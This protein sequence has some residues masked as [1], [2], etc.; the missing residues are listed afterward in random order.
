M[1]IIANNA[2]RMSCV[3]LERVYQTRT[4]LVRSLVKVGARD[5]KSMSIHNLVIK[6]EIFSICFFN[7][8]RYSSNQN[9]SGGYSSGSNQ[10]SWSRCTYNFSASFGAVVAAI[11]AAWG[12]Y[13][14]TVFVKNKDE[15]NAAAK[16]KTELGLISI[17]PLSSRTSD[18]K[19]EL[20]SQAQNKL[21]VIG[22]SGLS[23]VDPKKDSSENPIY[24]AIR[25]L[26]KR[27]VEVNLIIYDEK[28]A[29]DLGLNGS[30]VENIKK[31]KKLAQKLQEE[32]CKYKFN[33][34]TVSKKLPFHGDLIDKEK[35]CIVRV[36]IG[37][38]NSASAMIE[39]YIPGRSQYN[40]FKTYS[41]DFEEIW[42]KADKI[43]KVP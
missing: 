29:D 32:D 5:D 17:M 26:L 6:N 43:K 25:V 2:G 35:A 15:E 9:G 36:P 27:G 24:E 37:G 12:A 16:F 11:V 3:A 10:E 42:E 1:S 30:D 19:A 13:Q 20:Y 22:V 8:R 39:T 21:T 7:Q 28:K 40:K 31:T 18:A 34:R 38:F 23:L 41:A 33:V 4:P 14:G